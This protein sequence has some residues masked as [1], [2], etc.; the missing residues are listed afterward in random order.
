MFLM[1]YQAQIGLEEGAMKRQTASILW[2]APVIAEISALPDALGH[3][4]VGGTGSSLTS[5]FTCNNG[6]NTANP[7]HTCGNGGTAKV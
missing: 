2:E 3:C 7:A 4:I 6:F 1:A 5:V